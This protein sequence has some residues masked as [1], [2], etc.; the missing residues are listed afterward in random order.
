[1]RDG[2]AGRAIQSKHIC[3]VPM[4]IQ[5]SSSP[6]TSCTFVTTLDQEECI[7]RVQDILDI[8]AWGGEQG[9]NRILLTERNFS[10]AFYDLKTG[11]AGE[12]LQKLSNYGC[13]LAIEGTFTTVRSERFRELMREANAG[14]Q[15]RFSRTREE[16]I[17]WLTT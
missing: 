6:K 5:L 8:M 10:A 12:I 17:A 14:S 4:N 16:A 15:I 2:M 9:T 3:H 7:T 11:L 1:M 13:R